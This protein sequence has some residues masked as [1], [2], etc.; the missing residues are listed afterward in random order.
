VRHRPHRHRFAVVIFF[1][2]G[3]TCLAESPAIKYLLPSAVVPGRTTEV[4]VFGNRLAETI[5]LWTSFEAKC[6]KI[7]CSED[8]AVFNIKLPAGCSTGL[9]AVRLVATNG[10]SSLHLVMIDG[11][12]GSVATG[13]NRSA[14]TAQAL[15]PPVAVDGACEEKAADFYRFSARKGERLSFEVVAQRLGSPLDPMVRLLDSSGRELVFCEDT[16]GAGVDC[17]FSYKFGRGGQYLLELRDT[18]YEGGRQHR[19]RLRLGDFPL[20]TAPLA[21][22]SKPEVSKPISRLPQITESEPNDF[23]PQ[24]ISLPI[25]ISGRFGKEKDRD[26]FQF[27]AA[28]GERLVF[29]SRTRSLGS[30]CDCYLR[31]ADAAG[32]KLAESPVTGP[33]EAALTNIFKEAGTYQLQIEEVAQAG[34]PELFYR[35]EIEPYQPGF[36]LSVDTEKIQAASGTTVEISVA[37]ERH[38]YEGPITLSLDSAGEG[39]V[40]ENN[41]ITAKTNS[42]ALKV[43]LPTGLQP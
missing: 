14:A 26:C 4:T 11:L 27:E 12:P 25:S 19:Y 15:K 34:G 2:V 20:E 32:K 37:P 21:F 30:P 5:T 18:R 8:Q 10:A 38:D 36:A 16:P 6:E 35:V 29:R 7:R 33:D 42:T 9:G 13:T 22:L 43:K 31:L 41:V 3:G 1:F 40:L 39:F 17:R 24:K 28:K 23:K